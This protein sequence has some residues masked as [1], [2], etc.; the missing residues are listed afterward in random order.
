MLCF[1]GE[2][3]LFVRIKNQIV[4]FLRGTG[5]IALEKRSVLIVRLRGRFP[6]G[7]EAAL[8]LCAADEIEMRGEGVLGMQ[9]ADVLPALVAHGAGWVDV[10]PV[11]VQ[12][13]REDPLAVR[14]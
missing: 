10:H 9:V 8:A 14:L 5:V 12:V 2:V 7:E 3:A 6:T 13:R 4:E 1:P 11:V